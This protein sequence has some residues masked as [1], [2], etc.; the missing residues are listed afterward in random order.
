MASTPPR[1]LMVE[2]D[3]D[4]AM[5]FAQVLSMVKYQV[6]SVPDAESALQQLAQSPFDLLLVDWDLPGM[7]GDTLIT[8]VKAQ[9]PT[10][11]TILFSNHINVQEA[12]AACHADAWFRKSDDI[13]RLRKMVADLLEKGQS[14]K[15]D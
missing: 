4:Q 5:L 8:T 12:A 1:I 7:K 13:L 6:T 15:T 10:I 14:A 3:P 9:Y 2:D 11:P